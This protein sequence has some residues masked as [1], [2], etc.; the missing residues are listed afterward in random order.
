MLLVIISFLNPIIKKTHVWLNE[1]NVT[2]VPEY[3]FIITWSIIHRKLYRFWND[4][5]IL[6]YHAKGK[7]EIL[8]FYIF[9]LTSVIC[10]N[11][12]LWPDCQLL[13][14]VWVGF[15]RAG[16]PVRTGT[17]TWTTVEAGWPSSGPWNPRKT[18][19]RRRRSSRTEK[20]GGRKRRY[21]LKTSLY[22][23]M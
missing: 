21:G 3:Q 11:L 10:V 14:D 17:M 22:T 4:Q 20:G 8:L 19:E 7:S 23:L 13:W 12:W 15:Y 2:T 5:R 18:V 9:S 16:F 6:Q 1:K